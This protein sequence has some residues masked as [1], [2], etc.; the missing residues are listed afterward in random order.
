MSARRDLRAGARI[1]RAEFRRSVR[2][3]LRD[4]RRLAGVVLGTLLFS[5]TLLA[6]LPVAV[7]FGRAART[8]AAVPGAAVGA[9]LAPVGLVVLAALRTLERIGRVE[10][11]DL[12][13]LTVHPRAVVLGLVGAELARLAVWLGPP[14]LLVVGAFALGAGAPTLPVTAGLVALPVVACAAVWGYALG[15]TLLRAL[16][17]APSVRSLLKAVGVVAVAALALVPQVA[18]RWLS[19]RGVPTGLL[20][21]LAVPALTD[22]AALALVGTPL[23][24]PVAPAA[25]AVLVALVALVP[26]GVAVAT[27]QA[28]RLWFGDAPVDDGSA[29]TGAGGFA[30]PVP[31]A[32]TRVGRVAWGHLV[33]GVRRPESFGHLVTVLFFLGPVGSL[34]VGAGDATGPLIAATGAGLGVYL[35]GAAFGLNPLGEDRPHAPL[36][37]LSTASPRT[38]VRGRLVAGLAVGG[39]VAVLVPAGTVALGLSPVAALCFAA[40]GVALSLAAGGLAVGLGCAYPVYETREFWGIESVVPSTLVTVAYIIV[41]GVGTLVGLAV[42]WFALGGALS[43]GSVVAVGAALYAA[44]TVGGSVLSYRYAVRR[45]RRYTVE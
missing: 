40:L 6:V 11:E 37:L 20:D 36:L 32:S 17:R 12:V 44:L 21:R 30:P 14:T 24:R 23:A 2:G 45:Y 18:G 8:A 42:L 13:L 15:V 33:R 7:V 19:D 10:A 22:Y 1:A 3:Y 41:A 4:E 29:D 38:L 39:P 35:A 26:V 16:R 31:F 34:L 27:R 25:L 43:P 28:S 9:T 5:A